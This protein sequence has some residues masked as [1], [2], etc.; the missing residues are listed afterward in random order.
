MKRYWKLMSLMFVII[1]IFSSFYIDLGMSSDANPQIILKHESG[2]I[3][4]I[5]NM[6]IYGSYYERY[7]WDN[8]IVNVNDTTFF[9]NLSYFQLMENPYEHADI[10]RLKKQYRQ[11]MRGKDTFSHHFYEDEKLLAHVD[12][13][14]KTSFG[15]YQMP[16]ALSIDVFHKDS[17]LRETLHINI[18][19]ANKYSH[20]LIDGI[21]VEA[22]EAFVFTTNMMMEHELEQ[23]HIEV[24]MYQM[25]LQTE[26]LLQDHIVESIVHEVLEGNHGW[27]DIFPIGHETIQPQRH[28]IYMTKLEEISMTEQEE[29]G[30]SIP[31]T[32]LFAYDLLSKEKIAFELPSEI[33]D[34]VELASYNGDNLLYLGQLTGN[35]FEILVYDI[36]KAELKDVQLFDTMDSLE[37]ILAKVK[38]DKAYVIV[39]TNQPSKT[40]VSI[41]V[42]DL[43]T[44]EDLYIG[45]LLT[46]TKAK[47]VDEFSVYIDELV[48]E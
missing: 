23:E 32:K 31:E 19:D 46:D 28:L 20:I 34:N 25:D 35:Q 37:Y 15:Y 43:T 38:D 13:D 2:D 36:T 47:H 33:K 4:E 17:E 42:R 44:G 27:I 7:E 45:T 39:G 30:I 6:T 8:F 18:P 21:H 14:W 22:G 29:A 26:K 3:N 9:S 1:V 11:F 41:V 12:L 40:L 16:Y 5:S 24:H 48:I 10:K